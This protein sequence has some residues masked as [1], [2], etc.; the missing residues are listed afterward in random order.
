[1]EW[2]ME[3]LVEVLPQH[4][5][6]VEEMMCFSCLS[7]FLLAW[8]EGFQAAPYREACLYC[9]SKTAYVVKGVH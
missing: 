7:I 4:K 9:R 3:G 8:V 6:R 2:N 1:M 5:R